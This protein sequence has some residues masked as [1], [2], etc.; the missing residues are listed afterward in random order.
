[1]KLHEA[2]EP[3][4]EFIASE[5]SESAFYAEYFTRMFQEL[6]NREAEN[7]RRKESLVEESRKAINEMK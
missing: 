6:Q 2:A 5:D 3:M 7:L 4:S 1:M